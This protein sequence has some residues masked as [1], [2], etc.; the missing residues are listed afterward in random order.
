MI[1]LANW[2]HQWCGLLNIQLTKLFSFQRNTVA[3]VY[4]LFQIGACYSTCYSSMSYSQQTT[5][6]MPCDL[7]LPNIYAGIALLLYVLLTTCC[8]CPAFRSARQ[9]RVL[10]NGSTYNIGVCYSPVL[11]VF[12]YTMPLALGHDGFYFQP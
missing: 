5:V 10:L 1:V 3:N 7:Y 6:S 8:Q 9:V 12:T 11:C 4:F 2:L